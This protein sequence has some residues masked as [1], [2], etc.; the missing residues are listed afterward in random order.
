MPHISTERVAEIRKQIK[1]QFPNFKISV[2]CRNYSTVCIAIIEAPFNMLIDASKKY[3]DVN[4]FYI[5]EHY[6]DY[7]QIKEVLLQLYQIANSGNGTECEDGDYG[8]IPNF[9]VDINIGSWDKPFIV[10]EKKTYPP[11]DGGAQAGVA[12]SC[13]IKLIDYSEK[14]IAI[15]GDTKP[16]KET[17]K[18]LGGRFNFRLTCGAGWIFPKTKMEEVKI[19]LNLLNTNT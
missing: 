6:A 2:T 14:A 7:P 11:L 19:K 5:A 15:I 1:A 10:K 13:E 4:H 8:T 17:L 3:E 12:S 18:A 16:I 9:Y